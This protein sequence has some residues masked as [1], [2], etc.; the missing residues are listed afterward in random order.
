MYPVVAKEG[1]VHKS[2]CNSMHVAISICRLISLLQ[3]CGLVEIETR[4]NSVPTYHRLGP[5]VSS[6]FYLVPSW[7]DPQP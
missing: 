3:V 2:H 4:V 1:Y 5:P 7:K 6:S